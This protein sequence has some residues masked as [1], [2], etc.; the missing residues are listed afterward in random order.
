[1]STFENL[2]LRIDGEKLEEVC[3]RYGLEDGVPVGPLEV[4]VRHPFIG[5]FALSDDDQIELNEDG[6][7]WRKVTLCY[8]VTLLQLQQC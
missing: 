3:L 2:S 7:D 6:Q 5:P 1:M 8:L 4:T